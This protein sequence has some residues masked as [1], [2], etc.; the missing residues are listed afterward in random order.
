MKKVIIRNLTIK[1]KQKIKENI[2]KIKSNQRKNKKETTITRK[3]HIKNKIKFPQK[4]NNI[5]NIRNHIQVN[6]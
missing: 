3:K 2:N 1:R 4:Q 5:S 6:S